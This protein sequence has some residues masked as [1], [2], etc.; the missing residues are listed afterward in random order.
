VS[1]KKRVL[2]NKV[3]SVR[4]GTLFIS[5]FIEAFFMSRDKTMAQ[6]SGKISLMKCF[7]L[8]AY[9]GDLLPKL[10]YLGTYCHVVWYTG[11]DVIEESA[12]LNFRI[13]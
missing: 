10:W 11:T 8:Q 7:Y 6:I 12:A 3:C 9:G 1:K 5:F 4:G 2:E 13:S